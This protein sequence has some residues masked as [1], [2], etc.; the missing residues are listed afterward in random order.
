LPPYAD[1]AFFDK[2]NKRP[3]RIIVK[4]KQKNYEKSAFVSSCPLSKHMSSSAIYRF[5]TLFIHYS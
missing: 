5:L 3:Q 4:F 1:C 2:P